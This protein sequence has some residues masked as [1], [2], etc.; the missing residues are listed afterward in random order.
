MPDMAM[1]EYLRW[2][3][4]RFVEYMPNLMRVVGDPH[5]IDEFTRSLRFES[6]TWQ[7]KRLHLEVYDSA[8]DDPTLVFHGGI[9]TYVRF[10]LIFLSLLRE[11]GFNIVAVDRPGHGFSEGKRGDC[12]VEDVA[13]FVP[14]V[15]EKAESMFN[16]RIGMFGSSLGGITTFYLLPDLRGVRSALCHNWLYPGD[17]PDPSRNATLAL[18]RLI[19]PIAPR[20]SLPM[21][22]LL[23]EQMIQALSESPFMIDYFRRYKEDPLY[24]HSLTL[25]SVLSYFGQYRPKGQYSQ[26]KI[27]VMGLIAQKDGMLPLDFSR[28]GWEKAALP[29]GRLEVMP[30][31]HHMLFHDHIDLS[32]P[33]VSDW[34]KRTLA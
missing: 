21:G 33:V 27:P 31:T 4:K 28:A 7:G 23:G 20:L 5:R 16:D 13:S 6:V 19:R 22:F 29:N 10:Y 2:S 8:P 9:G 12:T 34:F 14:A 11:Q 3:Q 17:N 32:L 15:V 30:D 24:C 25:R 26:V 18:A 1:E